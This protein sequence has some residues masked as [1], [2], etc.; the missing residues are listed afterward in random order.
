MYR[1]IMLSKDPI[2]GDE[3]VNDTKQKSGGSI[4]QQMAR[5]S[6]WAVGMRWCLRGIG[7]VSTIILARILSP[8]D[9]GI[10]A[11]NAIV[12]GFLDLLSETGV[13]A[14][15]IRESRVTHE[16]CNTGWTMQLLQNAF[17][18]IGLVLVGP[19]GAWYFHEPR[20]V[21]FMQV[22]ALAS[23]IGG[24]MNI[25]M[26]LVRKELD[27]AR[28]FRFSVYSRLFTLVATIAF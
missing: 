14:F 3:R 8:A 2:V 6:A 15:L 13:A 21:G 7:L 18:A 11:M 12:V 23:L 16:L 26:V 27:F 17:I 4:Y 19:L 25:G 9:F 5:G 28:D 10:V 20:L 1:N 22:T 24:G